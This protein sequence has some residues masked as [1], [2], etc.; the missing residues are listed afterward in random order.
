MLG[1][2]MRSIGSTIEWAMEL[3]PLFMSMLLAVIVG[4]ILNSPTSSAALTISLD[5]SG[6]AAG[7][8]TAGCCAIMIGFAAMSYRENGWRGVVGIG[9]SKSMLHLL[10]K[11]NY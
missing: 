8:D 3:Q 11:A 7:A 1:D 2:M 10:H 5:L 6:L 4:M 9:L